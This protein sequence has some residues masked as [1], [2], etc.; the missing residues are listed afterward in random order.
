V[1]RSSKRAQASIGAGLF[2]AGLLLGAPVAVANDN[3]TEYVVLAEAGASSADVLR[4]IKE[5]G[6][7][8]TD[9]ND[10]IGSYTV[11]APADGFVEA[12]AAS[13]AVF[14]ATGQRP[15]GRLPDA[16]PVKVADPEVEAIHEGG[17]GGPRHGGSTAEMDPLDSFAWGL[18]MVKSDQAREVNAGDSRVLVG[19]LDS[20]IDASHPDLAGQLET[21]LSR[22]FVTDIPLVDGPCEVASCVDPATVDDSG[23]G[24]HVAGT[25]AAAANGLGVSGVA[26]GVR[27]VNIRGGQDSGYLFLA[28]VTNALTYGADIGVDVIN[29]SFYVDPWLYN[30]TANPADSPEDQLEQRT[31]IEAMNRALDYA[32]SKYVTLVGS[33]GNNH[34]DLGHPRTD[35]SSPDFPPG[36]A[37]PRPIDNASCWDLPVE[38]HHVIG[39]SALGPSTAKADYS[40]Y[41]LEQISL[42][43]PGGWFRD[44]FG[45]PTFRTVGNQILSTYPLRLLQDDGLV[46]PAGNITPDGIGFGVQKDCDSSGTCGYYAYL[47]G[48]SM[49]SPHATGVSALAVSRFGTKDPRHKGSLRLAPWKTEFVLTEGAAEHPCPVPP[50]R[51]YTNEGRSVEFNALCEGTT[52]F[53]GFY[54]YGIV[55]AYAAVTEQLELPD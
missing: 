18:T 36:E 27:L 48:T 8:V 26:P 38:G 52:E 3:Q 15:I 20:G 37:Y 7:T 13:K 24:T 43:A 53:N 46:D 31:I 40:N 30:C 12:V 4:A 21:S 34:E 33:L 14:G 39:V 10:A 35:F 32:H 23:H 22:N 9:R 54:G 28:P 42:S 51:T 50:L 41:G 5:A 45:T 25:V 11:L 17:P 44:G 2:I 29:M 49:A 1:S 47:Q 19:I 16:N 6:G 55:D